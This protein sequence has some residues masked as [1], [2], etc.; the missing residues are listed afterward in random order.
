[1]NE[2]MEEKNNETNSKDRESLTVLGDQCGEWAE[3]V[4]N[5]TSY[6]KLES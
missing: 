2:R 5:L 6:F 3:L 4:K 1:M